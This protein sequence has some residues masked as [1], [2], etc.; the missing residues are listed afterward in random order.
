MEYKLEIDDGDLQAIIEEYLLSHA[1][2][3]F[4]ELE[5]VNNRP[6]NIGCTLGSKSSSSTFARKTTVSG[7]MIDRF[8]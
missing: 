4:D 7:G 5:V 6:M 2:F 8:R 3:D 1:G